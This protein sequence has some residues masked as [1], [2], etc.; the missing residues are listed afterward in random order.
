M[1]KAFYEKAFPLALDERYWLPALLGVA[2][3]S[4]SFFAVCFCDFCIFAPDDRN[5][6]SLLAFFGGC[7]AG[8]AADVT[9]VSGTGSERRAINA[10]FVSC[11]FVI[12]MVG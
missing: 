4:Y 11:M 12:S 7:D 8:S 6:G 3:A 5:S 9:K 1:Q 2:A 10:F